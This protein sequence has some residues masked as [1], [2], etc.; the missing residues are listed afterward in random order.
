MLRQDFLADTVDMPRARLL[1][2]SRERI[3]DNRN[4]LVARVP[5]VEGVKTGHTSQAGYVL[6]GA[7]VARERDS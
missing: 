7:G 4:D 1:T 3:V 2:G 6:V 5:W